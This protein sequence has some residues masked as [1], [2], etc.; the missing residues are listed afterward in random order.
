MKLG[1]RT[2]PTWVQS[3]SSCDIAV[4]DFFGRPEAFGGEPE[5]SPSRFM[6]SLPM[7]SA[8]GG[9]V[10]EATRKAAAHQRA[11]LDALRVLSSSKSWT[12]PAGDA[13][14]AAGGTTD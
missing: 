8:L 7:G 6:V 4:A 12:G 2:C 1:G 13:W 14:I 9:T 5:D 10:E 11:E 3:D